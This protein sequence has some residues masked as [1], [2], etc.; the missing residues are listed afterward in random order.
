MGAGGVAGGLEAIAL[1][2]ALNEVGGGVDV[3]AGDGEDAFAL[4]FAHG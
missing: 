4:F 1:F 3:A 2:A